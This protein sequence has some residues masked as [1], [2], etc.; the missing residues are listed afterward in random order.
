MAPRLKRK[1][2][3][4]RGFKLVV[5][6]GARQRQSP[7]TGL[8]PWGLETTLVLQNPA[9]LCIC[10]AGITAES[11][12]TVHVKTWQGPGRGKVMEQ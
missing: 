1:E 8:N 3:I 12:A 4:D 6:N 9:C 11:N 2:P 5:S 7:V 10:K